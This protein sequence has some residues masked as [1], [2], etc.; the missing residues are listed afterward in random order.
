MVPSRNPGIDHLLV[1][2]ERAGLEELELVPRLAEIDTE[3][4]VFKLSQI[5]ERLCRKVLGARGPRQLDVMI[6]EIE[7]RNL[8]G[9]KA[10]SYLR[11]IQNL[12]AHATQNADESAEEMFT[13][14]DVNN[15]AA[16][17]ASVVEAALSAKRVG[18]K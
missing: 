12:G 11:H 1:V 3:C 15:T 7:Q 13:L 16:T 8:L 2:G 14:L 4:A 6:G 17:L 9:K 18:P 5:T 10:V